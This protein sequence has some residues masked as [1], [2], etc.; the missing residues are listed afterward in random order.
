MK[1][2]SILGQVFGRLTVV[3]EAPKDGRMWCSCRCACGKETSVSANQL[4]TGKTRSC[5]CLFAEAF[6]GNSYNR[7]HGMVGSPTYDAWHAMK[8]RCR[9]KRAE[10]KRNY[11]DRGIKV[12]ARWRDSFGNFLAD[13]GERPARTE[14]DRYP[15]NDG[16]YEP[17]NCRWASRSEQ[18]K[19][20]RERARDSAGRYA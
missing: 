17:G 9:S 13:M 1:K 20:R 15:D 3:A 18:A 10:V 7:Q 2:I 11:A 19:N 4:R 14:L 8:Q 6:K 5:G 12:C 16:N